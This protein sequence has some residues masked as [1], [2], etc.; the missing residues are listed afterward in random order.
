MLLAR[1]AAASDPKQTFGPPLPPGALVPQ[2][3]RLSIESALRNLDARRGN[4]QPSAFRGLP[5]ILSSLA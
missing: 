2:P 3:F 4:A 5:C 1:R